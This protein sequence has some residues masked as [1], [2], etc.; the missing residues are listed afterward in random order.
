MSKFRSAGYV[1]IAV[2]ILIGCKG[3]GEFPG[4]EKSATGLYSKFYLTNE[5]ARKP[6][7]GEYAAISV[8][9]TTEK[10]SEIFNSTAIKESD[11]GIITQPVFA[12]TFKG[13]FEEGLMSMAIGDSASFKIS[14]DSVY[15][16]T[17]GAKELPKYI[18]KGSKLTF[19]VKLHDVKT[20]QELLNE[21]SLKESKQRDEFL[22]A[23]NITV[24]PTETGLYIIETE[25]GK[26][27]NIK[28]GQTASVKYSGKFLTGQVFDG[29]ELHDGKPYDVVVGKGGVIAGWDE[30]LLKM[31]KGSKAMLVIP[32]SLGYGA[33]GSGPIPPY[34]SLIFDIEV[35]DVK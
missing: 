20:Q 4:Y 7:T 28:A 13:S 6:K 29:S 3:A 5:G 26:G 30:A 31:K 27:E 17:F 23:N 33:Q 14:A 10:D 18:T 12:P 19:Y 2:A 24:Q 32:S 22:K 21:M 34:S 11:H 16:K 1:T 8:R 25:A 9:Y 15:F 35:V